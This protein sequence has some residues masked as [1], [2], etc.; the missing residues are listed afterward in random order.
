MSACIHFFAE[1]I[2]YSLRNKNLLRKWICAVILAERKMAGEIN[3][4]FCDD[5]FLSE[6]NVKYLNH[7]SLTDIITF[8]F[9]E[10]EHLIAGEIYISLPRV[11]ENAVKFEVEFL[12]E[13]HRV[14]IHGILHL[15]GYKDSS[16][17]EKKQMRMKEDFYLAKLSEFIL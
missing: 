16:S 4:V 5:E 1:N 12:N 13:L 6:Y 9:G 10:E 11:R 17:G 2:Q 7:K 3:F 8:P 14:M 15:S